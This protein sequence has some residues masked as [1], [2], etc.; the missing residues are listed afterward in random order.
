[1]LEYLRKPGTK[2]DFSPQI[3]IN[4]TAPEPVQTAGTP[5]IV[6]FER[7]GSGKYTGLFTKLLKTALGNGWR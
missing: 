7:L 5:A 6:A 2:V 1:L 3:R 4:V